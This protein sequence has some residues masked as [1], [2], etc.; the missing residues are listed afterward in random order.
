MTTKQHRQTEAEMNSLPRRSSLIRTST[1]LCISYTLAHQDRRV[2]TKICGPTQRLPRRISVLA[3]ALP[4]PHYTI[5]YYDTT[6]Y[7]SKFASIRQKTI[8]TRTSTPRREDAA[9]PD[10]RL[11]ASPTPPFADARPLRACLHHAGIGPGPITLASRYHD[12][13][14]NNA[15]HH[16]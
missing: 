1:P 2:L 13:H 8:S 12:Q 7:K 10:Y 5:L 3:I 15:R 16:V 6:Q 9:G 4:H 11:A 14:G